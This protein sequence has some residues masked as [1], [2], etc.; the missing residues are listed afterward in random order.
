MKVAGRKPHLPL[1]ARMK[2]LSPAPSEILGMR[3]D[4][5]LH[6]VYKAVLLTSEHS[7]KTPI[8]MPCKVHYNNGSDD[9]ERSTCTDD[10]S[11]LLDCRSLKT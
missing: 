1:K 11:R 5:I 7:V 4:L 3:N 8:D 10:V 6:Q 9:R 2:D